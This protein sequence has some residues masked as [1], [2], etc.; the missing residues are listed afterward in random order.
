MHQGDIGG[1]VVAEWNGRKYLVGVNSFMKVETMH[2]KGIPL[3]M[4]KCSMQYP[5]VATRVRLMVESFIAPTMAKY[6]YKK[7]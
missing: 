5:N 1:P 2:R 6:T 4:D 7:K 3:P